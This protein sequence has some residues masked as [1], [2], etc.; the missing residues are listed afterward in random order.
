M[1][2][3][4]SD[5]VVQLQFRLD[6]L[7]QLANDFIL[8]DT[9]LLLDDLLSL[10]LS[11]DRDEVVN[12]RIELAG[13]TT[14]NSSASRDCEKRWSQRYTLQEEDLVGVGDIQ[15]VGKVSLGAIQDICRDFAAM[16]VFCDTTRR[17]GQIRSQIRSHRSVPLT[18]QCLGSSAAPGQLW[19]EHRWG[20]WQG[21]HPGR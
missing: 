8:T 16:A 19:Q 1:T 13:S 7:A 11:P 5:Q 4:S 21:Q 12:G 9:G 2:I 3:R 20:D 10:L 14:F 15:E 18:V 17:A 6:L